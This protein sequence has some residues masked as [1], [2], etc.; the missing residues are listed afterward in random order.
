MSDRTHCSYAEP[1]T[2]NVKISDEI[3]HRANAAPSSSVRPSATAYAA[4]SSR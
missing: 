2:P 1:Y 4:R 3:T